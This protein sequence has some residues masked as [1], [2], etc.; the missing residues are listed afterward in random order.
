[1]KKILLLS[2]AL[3]C[4]NVPVKPMYIISIWNRPVQVPYVFRTNK[5]MPGTS[6]R[7]K[8]LLLK[9]NMEECRFD[10]RKERRNKYG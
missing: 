9:L 2:A 7:G 1:M 4:L 6:L 5:T 8:C 10:L 3:L